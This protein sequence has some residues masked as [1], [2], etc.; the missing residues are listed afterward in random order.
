LNLGHQRITVP[1]EMGRVRGVLFLVSAA[2]RMTFELVGLATL[3]D[4][5][6]E[7]LFGVLSHCT[8]APLGKVASKKEIRRQLIRL[9]ISGHDDR[10]EKH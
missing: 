5:A 9:E 3:V 4:D 8:L 6:G 7:L 2:Q 10:L 1:E